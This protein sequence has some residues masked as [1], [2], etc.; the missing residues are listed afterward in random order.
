[1]VRHEHLHR[2]RLLERA[3]VAEAKPIET[4]VSVVYVTASKTFAGQIGGYTTI[5]VPASSTAAATSKAQANGK[6]TSAVARVSSSSSAAHRSSTPSE[7]LA[8]STSV[9]SSVAL[10]TAS[11]SAPT[12]TFAS[13]TKA[14]TSSTSSTASAASASSTSS[15][16][17]SSSG[18][19]SAGGK[20]G[21]AFGII[22]L[23]GAVLALVLFFIK[24]RRNAE[25]HDRLDDEK[26]D[27]FAAAANS[28]RAPSTHTSRTA[29][30][31]PRLSLR[32]VTQF[33]PN[34]GEKRQSRG[35]AL[36]LATTANS[37]SL[38]PPKAWE[39]PQGNQD[40]NRANPFGNHAEALDSPN[41]TGPAVIEE[42]NA[43]ASPIVA[44]AAVGVATS[45][46]PVGLTRGASKRGN[47]PK[48][49]DLTKPTLAPRGPPSP[50]GTEFSMSS[51]VATP[52]QPSQTGAAIAAAGGPANSAV[53]RVQL[54]FKPSM[55]DEL[56]LQ[57]GQLIRLLH[58]YDDGWALCIRLDRSQQ[59]VVPRTCL[60]TRPVKP[61]PAQNGPRGPPRVPQ[62][63]R[64]M[65]PSMNQG[66]GAGS[67][68]SNRPMTPNGQQRPMTPNGGQ[69]R[70][71]TPNG[72][73]RPMTPNGGQQRPM[74][75][76]GQQRP[77]T[78]NG[79]QQRPMTP[80]GSQQRPMAQGQGRARGPSVSQAQP[81]M[82][83]R[84][85]GPSVSQMQPQRPTVG[86]SPMN[87]SQAIPPQTESQPSTA[88]FQDRSQGP[89]PAP[90]GP[91][92]RKPVPGQAL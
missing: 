86:P 57:A 84:P 3:P 24:K 2:R 64:P 66:P 25:K 16:S 51:E 61:R 62:Q 45:S 87:P 22:C 80:N 81:P 8:G 77:M 67:P 27:I 58:E 55:D 43:N 39:K 40:Q 50:T 56:E 52:T 68:G 5:G 7:I 15:S 89:P 12:T 21:L 47:G 42:V 92:G 88:Q 19:M 4:I 54:D 23:V 32:P 44:A 60:S 63:G 70:P 28:N 18:G 36:T 74:T 10:L 73:Q 17:S 9:G 1:M 49:L 11:S 82:Q 65:S 53:H 91:V 69:Q 41:T 35:N 83:G 20:A 33:L 29:S 48:P 6:S 31:A 71:M 34:L 37:Q 59:G 46:P 72:Q 90:Q 26:N 38:A 85:R 79:G 30:T 78:P 76:N 13:S 75:P 14:A